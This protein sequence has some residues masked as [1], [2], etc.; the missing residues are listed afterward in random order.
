MS[1]WRKATWAL[2]IWNVLMILWAASYS[3]GVGDCAGEIG[4]ASSVCEAGR[5]IGVELGVSLII[6]VW[7][8]GLIVFGLVWLRSRP[9]GHPVV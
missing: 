3:V 7:F 2:V 1:K 6:F 8:T 9:K 5:A 4:T